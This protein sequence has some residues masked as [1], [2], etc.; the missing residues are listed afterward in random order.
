MSGNWIVEESHDDLG[1]F[2]PFLQSFYVSGIFRCINRSSFT[3]GCIFTQYLQVLVPAASD[4][5][6]YDFS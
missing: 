1:S 6:P 3:V 5:D 2:G 4:S